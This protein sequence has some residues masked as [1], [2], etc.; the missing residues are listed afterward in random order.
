MN[1]RKPLRAPHR[2]AVLR[3]C[4][5][6]A[7]AF[8][9]PITS[10][11]VSHT[12]LI[13]AHNHPAQLERLI[14]VLRRPGAHFVVHIDAKSPIEEFQLRLG[15]LADVS[16]V[17]ERIAVNWAGWSQIEATLS[18]IRHALERAPESRR[19]TL[20][21]GSCYPIAGNAQ[22]ATLDDKPGQ[23]IGARRISPADPSYERIRR[24]YLP[25]HPA[26]NP[27]VKHETAKANAPLRR[28]VWSFLKTLPDQAPLPL[29]YFKGSQWWSLTRD[30]AQH[31]LS[32]AERETGIVQT[33][34]YSWVPDESFIQTVLQASPFAPRIR[35]RLH[36]VDFS[37]ASIASGKILTLDHLP[38]IRESGRMFVR[39]V[40]PVLSAA[41]LDEI[42]RLRA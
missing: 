18:L 38:A 34:R 19:L 20:L 4:S 11:L 23:F 24:Y 22:L 14:S 15:A 16:L 2:A 10:R 5:P 3:R 17:P 27:R 32:F 25:D 8:K 35:P 37:R 39:K 12:Y 21:S 41:L 29:P 13:L 33:F 7:R 1:R 28:Y 36:Y 42:D 9:P 6:P 30:A 26:L 31:V 40:D